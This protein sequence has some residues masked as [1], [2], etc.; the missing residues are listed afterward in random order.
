MAK[1]ETLGERDPGVLMCESKRG[2]T[3]GMAISTPFARGGK[4]QMLLSKWFSIP[5][6]IVGSHVL[7]T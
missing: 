1:R 6:E 5:R 4:G 2:C 3:V 7:R